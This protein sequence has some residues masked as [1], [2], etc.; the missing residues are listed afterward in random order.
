MKKQIVPVICCILCGYLLFEV[1]RRWREVL[2]LQTN[3]V[4]AVLSAEAVN[5]K[6]GA[7]A[8]HFAPDKEAFI[9]AYFEASNLPLAVFPAEV[10]NPIRDTL[11]RGRNSPE[12]DR[13]RAMVFK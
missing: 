3:C 9:N 7:I 11:R 6:V 5:Q 2:L 10:L 8:P 12:A 13:I 4:I 1:A